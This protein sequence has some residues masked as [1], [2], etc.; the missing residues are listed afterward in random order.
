MLILIATIDEQH[1]AIEIL[2]SILESRIKK[3]IK[4]KRVTM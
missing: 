2:I 3:F 1:S 4:N